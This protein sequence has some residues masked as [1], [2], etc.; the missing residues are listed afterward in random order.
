M[1]ELTPKD[2]HERL[3]VIA[4]VHGMILPDQYV[5]SGLQWLVRWSTYNRDTTA[6]MV[7]GDMLDIAESGKALDRSFFESRN[8]KKLLEEA[9]Y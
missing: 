9:D 6:V 1:E 5:K 7:F 8:V 4:W 2:G 3:H